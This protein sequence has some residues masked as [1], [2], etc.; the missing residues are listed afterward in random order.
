MNIFKKYYY[1]EAQDKSKSVQ[2]VITVFFY[3]SPS[4]AFDLF[5]EMFKTK[6]EGGFSI[7]KFERIK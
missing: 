5:K 3:E 1:C 6:F 2:S 7:T 4:T